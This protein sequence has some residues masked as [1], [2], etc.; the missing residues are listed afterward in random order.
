MNKK[1]LIAIAT[2]VIIILLDQVLKV[3]VKTHMM[4]GDQIPLIG[5]FVVMHFTENSGMAFGLEW[6]GVIGKY[7]LSIFRIV[8]SGYI[9]YYIYKL[10]KEGASTYLI[11]F[12]SMILAGA[13]GNV[14]DCMFY[15]LIFSESPHFMGHQMAARFTPFGEG[16]GTFLQG[17]VVDMI[18][19]P[20]Y[21]G[22]YPAWVPVL[23]GQE[24]I[25]FQFIFNIADS[26]ISVG[27]FFIFIFQNT[28]FP[29]P[30]TIS[31]PNISQEKAIEEASIPKE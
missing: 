25:F 11:L 24:L 3:W 8:F 16:Y 30:E 23:G 26:A 12:V 29:K 1:A 19:C 27:I 20:I 15:G 6:G 17:K 22:T 5:N 14:L 31:S 7:F 2:V 4:L 9:V 18:F 13:I 10:I 28:F 21:H